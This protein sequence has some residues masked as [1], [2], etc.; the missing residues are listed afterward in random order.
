MFKKILIANRGEIAVRIERACREMGIQSVALYH[1]SDIGSL[2]VR[3]ADQAVR[4][5]SELGYQDQQ[6]IIQHALVTGAEAIHPGYGFLAEQA[7]FARACAA[8]ELVFIGPP[9]EVIAAVRDKIATLERVHA[10]G[11]H[12]APHSPATFGVGDLDGLRAAADALGYPLVIK[13]CRG[14]RGRGTR[15]VRAPEHL[16]EAVRQ[17]QAGA[18]AVFGDAQVYLERAILPSRYV[19]VQLL[20]DIHGNLIHLGERDSSI[21]R[22]NQKIVTEAPAPYLTQ[23]QREQLWRDAIEIARLFGCRNACT[24][25]FVIDDA[26]RRFFTEIKARIQIEHAITEILTRVD[27][28]CEQIRIASGDPLSIGQADVLLTGSAMQC[29]INAEDPWN[30]FLPSPGRIS[31]FRLPGGPFVRVDTYAYSGCE[32]PLHYDPIFAK[33][34]TWGAD[35]S[36]C[37]SRM[38]RALEECV[39]AGIQTNIPLLHGVLNDPDFIRGVYTTEF[40]RRP[41]VVNDTPERELHDLAAAAAVA[42]LRRTAGAHTSLPERLHSGWHQ[43]SRHLPE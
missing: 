17:A 9:A 21:Q 18:E 22:N 24:V 31:G 16:V 37:V 40:S 23:T 28:V 33:L 8:A 35:R 41:L 13:S 3:L 14:G 38:R 34:V 32:I 11:F 36:I 27:M 20:G 29:R 6:A 15:V 26:G 19:E 39:I 4:M 30:R 25:E 43:D 42:Y 12:T 2:H 5:T 7:D 10:A 1:P